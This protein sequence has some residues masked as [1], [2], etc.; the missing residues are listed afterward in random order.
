M[1]GTLFQ[2]PVGA[3][4]VLY[5]PP[6]PLFLSA[7]YPVSVE[8]VHFVILLKV[9]FSASTRIRAPGWGLIY[10]FPVILPLVYDVTCAE[11]AGGAAS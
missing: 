5:L 10:F 8:M 2:V 3:L 1:Q 11:T 4:L 6:R 7:M 9:L